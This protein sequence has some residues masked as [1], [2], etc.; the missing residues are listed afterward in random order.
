MIMICI[1]IFHSIDIH[2]TKLNPSIQLERLE[3]FTATRTRES[4]SLYSVLDEVAAGFDYI[5]WLPLI[6]SSDKEKRKQIWYNSETGHNLT[7]VTT[8]IIKTEKNIL[9]FLIYLV[10]NF[11]RISVKLVCTFNWTLPTLLASW[12]YSYWLLILPIKTKERVNRHQCTM[13][14]LQNRD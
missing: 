7:N 10:F 9:I 5:F 6:S 14:L 13:H 3:T 4:L 8:K 2:F 11:Q 1:L 12:S